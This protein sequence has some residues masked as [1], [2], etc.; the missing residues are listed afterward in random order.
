MSTS[1]A[2]SKSC[3]FLLT[4]AAALA[5][6]LTGCSGEEGSGANP[7]PPPGAHVHGD[8]DHGDAEHDHGDGDHD[9]GDAGHDHGDGGHDHGDAGHDHG[10]GGHDH[11]DGGT[12]IVSGD[13]FGG[14]ALQVEVAGAMAPGG[15]LHV[16]GEVV[17]G[18]AT[19]VLRVWIGDATGVH[20]MKAKADVVKGH[21]H[22]HVEVPAELPAGA[23]LWFEHVGGD[24]EVQTVS[25]PLPGGDH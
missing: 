16:A 3:M 18:P 9:H 19:D 14:R 25:V 21:F 11:G 17:S 8:H 15:E 7:T 22:V 1:K 13:S 12:H 10:D 5:L 24:G 6:G 23:A 20:S 2:P 4:G